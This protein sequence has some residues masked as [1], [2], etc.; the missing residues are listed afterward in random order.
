MQ[1]IAHF[2]DTYQTLL[3]KTKRYN[4]WK[5]FQYV[6]VDIRRFVLNYFAQNRLFRKRKWP[7]AFETT[8]TEI[9]STVTERE[10]VQSLTQNCLSELIVMLNE[11]IFFWNILKKNGLN[12]ASFLTPTAEFAL[13]YVTKMPYIK[14]VI[15]LQ[16]DSS[17]NDFY[18]VFDILK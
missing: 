2:F 1:N 18:L 6:L 13:C 11:C 9:I 14:I 17:C 15:A 3:Q 8:W 16:I 10:K 7:V 5:T 4:G 12:H